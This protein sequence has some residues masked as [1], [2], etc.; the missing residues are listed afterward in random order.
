MLDARRGDGPA[1]L[2]ELH[3]RVAVTGAIRAA[4]QALREAGTL[5]ASSIESAALDAAASRRDAAMQKRLL[6]DNPT[7]LHW[8]A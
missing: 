3:G 2:I 7:R 4:L 6:V 5:P 8:A 1:G